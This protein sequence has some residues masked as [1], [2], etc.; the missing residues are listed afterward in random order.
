MYLDSRTSRCAV[1]S[2]YWG[3]VACH[4]LLGD[5]SAL[6]EEQNSKDRISWELSLRGHVPP[7]SLSYLVQR[8]VSLA[9][10][11]AALGTTG[12]RSWAAS[13]PR[14]VRLNMRLWHGLIGRLY[15]KSPL[16]LQQNLIIL[17]CNWVFKTFR[18]FVQFRYILIKVRLETIKLRQITKTA[19]SDSSNMSFLDTFC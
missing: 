6:R 11:V 12:P 15:K 4:V 8:Y 3:C 7:F 1:S 5:C 16:S 9:V 2:V 14:L 13:A 10:S 18:R 17:F 19:K